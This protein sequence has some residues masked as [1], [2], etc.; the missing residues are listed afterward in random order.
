VISVPRECLTGVHLESNLG[1]HSKIALGLLAS[2][3][4]PSK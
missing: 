4:P 2:V 1:S 3:A